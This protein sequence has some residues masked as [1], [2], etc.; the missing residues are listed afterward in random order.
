MFFNN[1]LTLRFHA[2][3]EMY[4]CKHKMSISFLVKIE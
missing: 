1:Q 3:N 2:N 4:T